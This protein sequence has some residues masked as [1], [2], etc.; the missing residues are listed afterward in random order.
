MDADI[1]RQRYVGDAISTA[2]PAKLVTML[3]DRLVR[4][5][6]VAE[7]ALST[8]DLAA[9]NANLT[10]AQEIVFELR[11]S[12]KPDMKARSSNFVSRIRAWESKRV[13]STA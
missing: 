12:L 3:Y 8:R 2:S 11:S 9:A 1:R 6:Q 5:L 7:A 13:S 4:D 10:H